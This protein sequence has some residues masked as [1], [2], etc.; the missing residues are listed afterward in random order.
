MSIVYCEYTIGHTL[1]L[2]FNLYG[3]KIAD[4]AVG[5][6]LHVVRKLLAN[7]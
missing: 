2:M 6:F 4:Y 3:I 5:N 7:V 1:F